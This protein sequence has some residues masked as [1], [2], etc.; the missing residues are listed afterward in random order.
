MGLYNTLPVQMI[1]PRCQETVD[2]E[3]DCYFGYRESMKTFQI[4]DKYEWWL[5]KAV[6]NGGRPP[7]GDIDGEGYAECP[8]CNKDFFV[9][10]IVRGDVI[11]GVEPDPSRRYYIPDGPADVIDWGEE[12]EKVYGSSR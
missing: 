10:V 2:V 1:C 8:A 4:G 3:V 7:D 11:K 6:Q 5:G 9:K 12:K